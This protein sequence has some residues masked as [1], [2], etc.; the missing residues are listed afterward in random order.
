MF[1]FVFVR[2]AR[3]ERG[4]GASLRIRLEQEPSSLGCPHPGREERRALPPRGGCAAAAAAA[5][6]G[7]ERV[8][9]VVGDGRGELLELRLDVL[10][11]GDLEELE[12]PSDGSVAR[13]DLRSLP[14]P[15]RS[16]RRAEV[17]SWRSSRNPSNSI[18]PSPSASTRAN[19]ARRL[20]CARCV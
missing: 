1:V 9:L 2:A 8:E 16:N 18:A 13:K 3:K 5:A 7:V 10:V 4:G 12:E 15:L 6:V 17:R 19:H 11:V 14:S 20:A